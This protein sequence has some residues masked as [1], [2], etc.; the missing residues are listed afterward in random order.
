MKLEYKVKS[1][2]EHG[3]VIIWDNGE[4]TPLTHE[5]YIEMFVWKSK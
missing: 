1:K 4:Q 5:Q 3:G 2:N